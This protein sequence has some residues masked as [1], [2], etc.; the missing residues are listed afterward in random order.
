[1]S[2]S[3][4]YKFL[5]NLLLSNDLRDLESRMGGFNVFRAL[6]MESYEIR[7]SQFLSYILNPN[8]H[9]GIGQRLL[10]QVLITFSREADDPPIHPVEILTSDLSDAEVLRERW[11]IDILIIV[12]SI[13][14]VCAIE[15]KI[16]AV[17]SRHQLKKYRDYVE[18]NYPGYNHLFVFL[19]PEG[20]GAINDSG[21][22]SCPYDKINDAIGFVQND[23]I[24]THETLPPK[25]TALLSDY[26]DIIRS[27]IMDNSE[28]REICR[29]IYREHKIAIDLIKENIGDIRY[30]AYELT[31]NH[32]QAK[33]GQGIIMDH[34]YLRRIR[35]IDHDIDVL[36]KRYT[37]DD[38]KWTPSGRAC[39]FEIENI[40]DKPLSVCLVIRAHDNEE[41]IK[42]AEMLDRSARGRKWI[43]VCQKSLLEE[44]K[45]VDQYETVPED[46]IK[47][48]INDY[49]EKEIPVIRKKISEFL[50]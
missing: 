6:G 13:K 7:H 10:K 1:M 37:F 8:N 38:G 43:R 26:Q 33:A 42:L 12:H 41:L 4:N 2:N 49:I 34:Y 11:N 20:R 9:H 40:P 19:T 16:N 14:L 25:T 18:K 36:M 30:D 39:L 45:S 27:E 23:A 48:A 31:K 35:F 22:I 15:N 24:S 3:D 5:E 50:G 29:K 28:L 32:L 47:S 46:E 21:W 44:D 17:E